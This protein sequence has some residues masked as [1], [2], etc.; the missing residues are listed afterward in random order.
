M[1]KIFNTE[2]NISLEVNLLNNAFLDIDSSR[3]DFE[4]WI[5]FEFTLNVEK[6]NYNYLP[7][8]GATFTLYELRNCI[9]NFEDSI[10]RKRNGFKAERYE[11]YSSEGYFDIIISNPL[12]ENLLSIEIWINIGSLTNGESF[13]YNK[14]FRFDVQ[15]D[16]FNLFTLNIKQQLQKIV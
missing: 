6:E 4:N 12:E 8:V 10:D 5:P 7:Q 11:F 13:G 9:I 16:D 15:L 2:K 1:P 3:E 14:G